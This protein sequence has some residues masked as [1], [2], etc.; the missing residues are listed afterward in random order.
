[1]A[2]RHSVPDQLALLPRSDGPG[3]QRTVDRTSN[4]YLPIEI[5]PGGIFG[6]TTLQSQVTK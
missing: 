3:A 6:F 1:M 4:F 2:R 5:E